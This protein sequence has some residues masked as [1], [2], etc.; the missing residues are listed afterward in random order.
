MRKLTPND[1][2]KIPLF[3]AIFERFTGVI[4]PGGYPQQGFM[5]CFRRYCGYRLKVS[6][7]AEHRGHNK[8]TLPAPFIGPTADDELQPEANYLRFAL[9]KMSPLH[10]YIAR[11]YAFDHWDWKYFQT[12]SEKLSWSHIG[13]PFGEDTSEVNSIPGPRLYFY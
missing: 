4:F 13:E 3:E 10:W 11:D 8:W 2:Q 9:I 12:V 6:K 1:P 5:A 7:S